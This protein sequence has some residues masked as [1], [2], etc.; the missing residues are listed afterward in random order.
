MHDLFVAPAEREL[1]L[2]RGYEQVM[3]SYSAILD[4]LLTGGENGPLN[5]LL[6]Q[7]L[8]QISYSV[9]R[10]KQA[11]LSVLRLIPESGRDKAKHSLSPLLQSLEGFSQSQAERLRAAVN[12]RASELGIATRVEPAVPAR[13]PNWR[14]QAESWSSA[15][16]SGRF[17]S[18]T[19]P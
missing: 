5:Q 14:R 1:A 12:R 8:D 7:G 2:S 17:R 19:C 6:R 4:R 11:V 15:K 3:H 18:T 13:M 9:D 10:E 16:G